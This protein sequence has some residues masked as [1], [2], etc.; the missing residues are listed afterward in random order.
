MAVNIDL[1]IP[2]LFDLPLDE[3]DSSFLK[4]ELPALNRLLRFGRR[5]RNQAFDL[6]SMLIDSMGW[7]DL[8]ALPYAQAYASKE[9]RNSD[10]NLLFRAIH[11]KADMYSAIVLP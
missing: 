5:Y 6:D 11:L 7:N 8:Q 3:L 2:G 10:R 4:F 9:T 1:I